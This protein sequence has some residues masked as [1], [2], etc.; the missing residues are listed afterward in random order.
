M[1]KK[2]GSSLNLNKS[3]FVIYTRDDDFKN[4]VGAGIKEPDLFLVKNGNE[5]D[6]VRPNVVRCNSKNTLRLLFEIYA[7]NAENRK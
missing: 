3:D 4:I 1:G 2:D 7:R 5:R 6:S